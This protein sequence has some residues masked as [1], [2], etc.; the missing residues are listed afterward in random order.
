MLLYKHARLQLFISYSR[1]HSRSTSGNWNNGAD[2]CVSMMFCS[3]AVVQTCTA[4]IVYLAISR[5]HSRSTSGNWNNGADVYV[6]R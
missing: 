3:N 1:A 2:V 4:S 5:A 6:C